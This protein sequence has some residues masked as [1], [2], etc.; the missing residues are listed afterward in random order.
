MEPCMKIGEE[1][2]IIIKEYGHLFFN[3]GGNDIEEL[4]SRPTAT[5]QV[6]AVVAL[7]QM[8]CAD[9]LKLLTILKKEGLLK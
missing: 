6:N 7:L 9:Q 4:L 5:I 8:S 1:E 3:T 2:K